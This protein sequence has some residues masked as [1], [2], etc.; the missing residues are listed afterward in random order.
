MLRAHKHWLPVLFWMALIFLVSTDVGSATHTSRI[1]EP[2]L[3]WVNPHISND[4]LNLAHTLVRK[5]GHLTEY[6]ILALLSLR[7]VLI[8]QRSRPAENFSRATAIALA[9]AVMYAAS[10]EFHQSFVAARTSS[11][12]DVGIDSLGAALALAAVSVGRMW[13]RRHAGA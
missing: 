5:G 6:A 2:L 12:Y 1:I 4:G 13:H 7:A 3:R 9:V 10:D 8:D 11:I